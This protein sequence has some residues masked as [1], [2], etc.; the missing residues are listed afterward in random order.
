MMVQQVKQTDEELTIMYMKLSKKKL[1]QMLIEC[2][3]ILD[4]IQP[5][6]VQ[7]YE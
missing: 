6:I 7:R 5:K 4:K 3:K 1:I 2:N